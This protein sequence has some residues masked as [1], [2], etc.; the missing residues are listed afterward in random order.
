MVLL[1]TADF[2][3]L[4]MYSLIV[5]RCVHITDDTE[6]DGESVTITHQSEFQ[7]QSIVLT[8]GIMNED[9]V[10]GIAILANLNDL[11]TESLLNKSELIIL[12]KDEFL[13][14]FHIDG[15]L[16]ASFLVIYTLMSSVIEDNTVLQNLTDG[17]TLML[18]GSL[19][20]LDGSRR[21]SSD[22]TG[23]EMSTGTK[24]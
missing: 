2:L 11:Q 19:Q 15:V 6:C 17:S 16:L 24:T 21:I 14:M 18:V 8:M 5:G 7:L 10:Q 20:D 9:I 13:S 1:L 12:S 3:Y 23:E 22:G 4:S